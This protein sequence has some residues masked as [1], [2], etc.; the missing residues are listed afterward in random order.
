MKDKNEFFCDKCFV[1]QKYNE[2]ISFIDFN[3]YLIIAF[4]RG[5][6]Y[7]SKTKVTFPEKL[8]IK[9]KRLIALEYS[10]FDHIKEID[11][12]S[13]LKIILKRD[14]PSTENKDK[15]TIISDSF[16]F[17]KKEKNKEWRKLCLK[18]WLNKSKKKIK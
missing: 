4:N 14:K 10:S 3:K 5:K 9:V 1:Y 18:I 2:E 7:A 16:S 15:K 12:I 8:V 17:K 6:N 13:A 11:P